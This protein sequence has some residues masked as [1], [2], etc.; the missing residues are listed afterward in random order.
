MVYG[1]IEEGWAVRSLDGGDTWEQIAEG[2][3][4]DGHWIVLMPQPDAVVASTGAG[5]FRSEDGGLHWNESNAGLDRRYTA[6]PIA[7]HPSRPETLLTG[8][9]AVGPGMWRR[10]EGADSA[11]ARSDDG[12]R[13]WRESTRGLPQP[14]AAP[15]RALA[16][17]PDDPDIF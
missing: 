9:T 5:M 6:A 8:V 7:V 2:I 15:P 16:V 10:P 12:G 3:D 1:A 17:D 4:H 13:T 11:F 14:C